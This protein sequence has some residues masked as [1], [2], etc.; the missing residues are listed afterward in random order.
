MVQKTLQAELN[1]NYDVCVEVTEENFE[2]TLGDI[3]ARPGVEDK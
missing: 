1:E 2:T 3:C